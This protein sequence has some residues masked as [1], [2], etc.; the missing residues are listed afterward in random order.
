MAR[1]LLVLLPL[2]PLE[3][4]VALW[5]ILPKSDGTRRFAYRLLEEQWS[6]VAVLVL[7]LLPLA[8]EQPAL[9]QL[10]GSLGDRILSAVA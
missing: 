3:L 4:G 2:P 5:S 1:G 8:G 7:L 9:L 6:I 10:I